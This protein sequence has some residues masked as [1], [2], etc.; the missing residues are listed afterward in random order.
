[1]QTHPTSRPVRFRSLF[2]IA[3]LL[4][5]AAFANQAGGAGAG[6]QVPQIDFRILKIDCAEDPGIF[7]EGEIPEGCTPVEG[8]YFTID[9]E[10]GDTLNCT[11]NADGRCL[12]QVPSEANVL[13][14]EDVSSG[15][16]GYAPRE[17]PVE[18]VAANE[19]AGAV[20]VNLPEEPPTTGLPDTGAGIANLADP[21]HAGGLAVIATLLLLAGALVTLTPSG[22][23]PRR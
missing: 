23:R 5:L 12:V 10:D 9:I 20:F 2:G 13:V 22:I 15:T 16:D 8:V 21:A 3:L 7:P 17:N 18:T 4:A 14:T 6:T 11:T 1:M 19:F